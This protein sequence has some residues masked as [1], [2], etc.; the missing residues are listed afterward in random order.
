MRGFNPYDEL[1]VHEGG[2]HESGFAQPHRG[3]YTTLSS[4]NVRMYLIGVQTHRALRRLCTMKRVKII[5]TFIA[6]RESMPP[7]MGIMGWR[8]RP[9]SGSSVR[10]KGDPH[11]FLRILSLR[12][13]V[14]RG[15]SRAVF[16]RR[17]QSIRPETQRRKRVSSSRAVVRL[18]DISDFNNN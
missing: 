4:H 11:C 16:S 15:D 5:E 17:N 14:D 9:T 12:D 7:S 18:S 8:T 2:S 1:R 10:S 13:S 6:A 3:N